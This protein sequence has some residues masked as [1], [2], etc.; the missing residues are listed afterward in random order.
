MKHS[1]SVSSSTGRPPAS[2]GGIAETLVANR[3]RGL[4]DKRTGYMWLTDV[5]LC[6]PDELYWVQTVEIW[7]PLSAMWKT[8]AAEGPLTTEAV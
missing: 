5:R 8:S 3:V 1:V 4:T 6:H 2:R 7:P